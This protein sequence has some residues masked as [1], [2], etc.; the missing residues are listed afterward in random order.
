MAFNASAET[1]VGKTQSGLTCGLK[2]ETCASTKN[3]VYLISIFDSENSSWDSRP[4][5]SFLSLKSAHLNSGQTSVV[6]TQ[7]SASNIL[8]YVYEKTEQ[9]TF[10]GHSSLIIDRKTESIK[11][12]ILNKDGIENITT[13]SAFYGTLKHYRLNSLETQKC[14]DMVAT[15]T[16]DRRLLFEESLCEQITDETNISAYQMDKIKTTSL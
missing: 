4:K 1:Y 15:E 6:N 2:I 11:R 13:G 16:P 9:G 10:H 8:N 7:A 12:L 3:T 14:F 5:R